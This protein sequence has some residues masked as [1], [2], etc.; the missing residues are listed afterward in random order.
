MIDSVKAIG[1]KEVGGVDE[2]SNAMNSDEYTKE[3]QYVFDSISVA[4]FEPRLL[5]ESRQ[6]DV[7]F[8]DQLD[9]YR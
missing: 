9:V 5:R 7:N 2:E 1:L 8:M 3:V 6:T 4:E